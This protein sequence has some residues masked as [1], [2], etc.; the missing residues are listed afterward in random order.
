MRSCEACV[1]NTIKTTGGEEFIQ[2][3]KPLEI[4]EIDI[5][6]YNQQEPILTLI[7]YYTRTARAIKLESK[8]ALE[9]V[10]ALSTI[11]QE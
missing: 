1:D 5:L 8:E 2:T 3:S 10:K 11:F 9:I 7:D 6:Q 4:V